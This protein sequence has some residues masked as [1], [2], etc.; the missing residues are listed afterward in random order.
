[1]MQPRLGYHRIEMVA[2]IAHHIASL[3]GVR[4]G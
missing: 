1:M 4:K 2:R 3:A